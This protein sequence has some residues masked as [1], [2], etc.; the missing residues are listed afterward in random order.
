MQLLYNSLCRLALTAD[1][2]IS[3][4]ELPLETFPRG[5]HSRAAT[6]FF[7]FFLFLFLFFFLFFYQVTPGEH[8]RDTR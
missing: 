3:E 7:L 6:F 1:R 5:P 8:R 4:I 2:T